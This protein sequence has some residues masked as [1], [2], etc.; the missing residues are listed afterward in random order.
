MLHKGA[1]KWLLGTWGWKIIP[2]RKELSQHMLPAWHN[3]RK[4]S[5]KVAVII[6]TWG[7]Y[8]Q[9]KGVI[10]FADEAGYLHSFFKW[11]AHKHFADS[12]AELWHCLNSVRDSSADMAL[13]AR[14]AKAPSPEKR[15]GTRAHPSKN[16]PLKMNVI[17]VWP[18]GCLHTFRRS[19]S[20]C[21]LSF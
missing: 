20:H 4:R 14:S 12:V 10:S 6:T 11:E 21:K 15:R 2:F 8:Y 7:N 13:M 19:G 5:F 17:S 1:S 16:Y 18:R 3:H 9:M